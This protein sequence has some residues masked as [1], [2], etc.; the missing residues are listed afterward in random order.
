MVGTAI[1]SKIN[2]EEN[3]SSRVRRGGEEHVGVVLAA[4]G[5]E[6][7]RVE[8][9]VECRVLR[10][11]NRFVVLVERNGLEKAHINNTGSLRGV[12]VE[13]RTGYCIPRRGGKTKYR[14]VAIEC[15][16]HRDAVLIDTWLQMRGFEISTENNY[17]PWLRDCKVAK[18]NPRVGSSLLDYL[19]E[20]NSREVYVEVKSATLRLP[21]DKA[22]YPEPASPR[23]RRHIE[24]LTRLAL[25]GIRALLVF[26]A[27]IPG[28]KGFKI[29]EKADPMLPDLLENAIRTGVIV[30]A[31]S[32]TY[33]PENN[34]II[35]DNPDLAIDP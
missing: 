31:M 4:M 3:P 16:G 21:G 27:G 11:L 26:I 8:K 9:V 14:L 23:G 17:L 13:G 25:R 24:E 7:L 18:R 20:C 33:N 29:N 5:V 10:R 28:A 34:A 32:I 35:L 15:P 22:S 30:K 19:L 2:Y 1:N 6:L 12:L